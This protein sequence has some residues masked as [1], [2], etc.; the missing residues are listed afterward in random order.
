[1]NHIAI[2]VRGNREQIVIVYILS[3]RD[4]AVFKVEDGPENFIL[5]H[6]KMLNEEVGVYAL[7]ILPSTEDPKPNDKNEHNKV[8]PESIKYDKI[9]KEFIA[10]INNQGAGNCTQD[11]R[12]YIDLYTRNTPDSIPY[13][14]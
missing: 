7:Q 2:G 14:K 3:K 11:F 8:G 12:Y 6:G 13:E 1:M 10:K 9:K 4:M 5:V